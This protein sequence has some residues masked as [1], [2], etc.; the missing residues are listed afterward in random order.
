MNEILIF[1]LAIVLGA[2]IR[3]ARFHHFKSDKFARHFAFLVIVLLIISL[4]IKFGILWTEFSVKMIVIFEWLLPVLVGLTVGY[5]LHLWINSRSLSYQ[6]LLILILLI[7]VGAGPEYYSKW[8]R[9]LGIQEI[10]NVKFGSFSGKSDSIFSFETQEN[11][12]NKIK[13]PSY[14]L[15]GNLRRKILLDKE[16]IELFCKNSEDQSCKVEIIKYLEKIEC[17]FYYSLDIISKSAQYTKN[18]KYH[19]NYDQIKTATNTWLSLLLLDYNGSVGNE[20][21]SNEKE[22]SEKSLQEVLKSLHKF[23]QNEN[24]KNDKPPTKCGDHGIDNIDAAVKEIAKLKSKVSYPYVMLAQSY[25]QLALHGEGFD[26]EYGAEEILN[27]QIQWIN[28]YKYKSGKLNHEIK[29]VFLVRAYADLDFILSQ[30]Q[31]YQIDEK[32][33]I[34][35]EY[36]D[37]LQLL[38]ENLKKKRVFDENTVDECH[39]LSDEFKQNKNYPLIIVAEIL[40]KNNYL[41]NASR[42]RPIN[43]THHDRVNDYVKTIRNFPLDQCFNAIYEPAFVELTKAKFLDTDASVTCSFLYDTNQ[44]SLSTVL[45]CISKWSKA[46]A[47]LEPLLK[48][49]DDDYY[50]GRAEDLSN[51]IEKK[52]RLLTES[53]AIRDFIQ[54]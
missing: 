17:I 51:L 34:K 11:N 5:L 18:R 3:K 27:E 39:Q 36:I 26:H 45:D 53:K 9:E 31:Q 35:Q 12:T 52:R 23:N 7:L 44:R 50:R 42:S 48:K 22:K 49:P 28:D 43:A 32:L 29:T 15:I 46:L 37:S 10:G 24:N 20:K 47:I 14:E 41:D 2:L 33:D 8:Q 38:I 19:P 54:N 6:R 13:N 30:N 21:T 16:R 25:L 1:A 40:A 4:G